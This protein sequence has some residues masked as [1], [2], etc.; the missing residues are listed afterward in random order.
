[1]T[2][3]KVRPDWANKL[4]DARAQAAKRSA[5]ATALHNA[6]YLM[7]GNSALE[8]RFGIGRR[9]RNLLTGEVMGLSGNGSPR[10]E[11]MSI[12][13]MEAL[14]SA[15][16]GQSSSRRQQQ[17]SHDTLPM[18]VSSR[19]SRTDEIEELML[20][21][22]IRQSLIAEEERKRKEEKE[23]AKR[24]KKDEKE[25][26]KEQKKAE[27]VAK[28]NGMYSASRSSSPAL[29]GPGDAGA[30]KGKE[31]VRNAYGQLQNLDVTPMN[32]LSPS[33]ASGSGTAS[34]KQD[35]QKF[36]EIS[37]AHLDSEISQNAQSQPQLVPR[38]RSRHASDASSTG[39]SF[40]DSAPGS[41]RNAGSDSSF[42]ASP[43][44]SGQHLPFGA[45]NHDHAGSSSGPESPFNF[46]S[47]AAVLGTD[48]RAEEIGH[49]EQV[50]MLPRMRSR[51]N[52]G[53]SSIS[54]GPPRD[55][56]QDA[57]VGSPP[58]LPRSQSEQY[59][60][61]QFEDQPRKHHPDI[62]VVDHAT[63]REASL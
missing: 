30:G 15:L 6:A 41:L 51:G 34:P 10:N 55:V 22:A 62:N 24:V 26:V 49:P 36:L 19:G 35:P 63:G 42:N 3:D 45:Q 58:A 8:Q 38:N 31:K 37:R 20:V 60:P 14:L 16:E 56:Q 9:R 52:T 32:P 33:S 17:G 47:L 13:N 7:G 54:L 61:S 11:G 5:A 53:E 18:R 4:S 59:R 12:P 48:G 57:T 25:R 46:G 40:L 39:S 21:E 23:N 2:T 29:S 1:V 27:K 43:N 50:S 44:I 28:K